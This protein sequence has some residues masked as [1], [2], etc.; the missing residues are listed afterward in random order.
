MEIYLSHMVLFRVIEKLGIN[1][2]FGNGWMQYAVTV[3]FVF[4]GAT[5][6]AVAM[7]RTIRIVMKRANQR[8]RAANID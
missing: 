2:I 8:R 6:F 3:V 7:Q 1:Q 5:V 4:T